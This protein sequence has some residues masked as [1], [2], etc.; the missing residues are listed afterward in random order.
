MKVLAL[1]G[2]EAALYMKYPQ[3]RFPDDGPPVHSC[4]KVSIVITG[5]PLPQESGFTSVAGPW[6]PPVLTSTLGDSGG[7]AS[8]GTGR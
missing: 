1:L 3:P 4:P 7:W 8:W 6:E 5:P 2:L